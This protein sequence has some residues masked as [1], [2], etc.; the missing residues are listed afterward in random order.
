M[1]ETEAVLTS[2][3]DVAMVGHVIKPR[4]LP[5]TGD[6]AAGYRLNRLGEVVMIKVDARKVMT[7]PRTTWFQMTDDGGG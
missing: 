1:W 7:I 3:P 5:K 6:F 4:Q 2:R